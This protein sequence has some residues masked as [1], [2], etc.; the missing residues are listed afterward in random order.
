MFVQG[1]GLNPAEIQSDPGNSQEMV[2]SNSIRSYSY[3]QSNYDLCSIYD[4]NDLI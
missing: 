4:D 1:L 3:S 2:R